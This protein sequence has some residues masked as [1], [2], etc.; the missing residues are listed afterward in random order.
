MEELTFDAVDDIAL[1]WDRYGPSNTTDLPVSIGP[2]GPLIELNSLA[3][4]HELS[5]QNISP[6]NTCKLLHRLH[7]RHNGRPTL[8]TEGDES[9]GVL[10]LGVNADEDDLEFTEFGIGMQAAARAAGIPVRAAQS[11]V[12]AI[13]EM[14]DNVLEHSGRRETALLVFRSS[15]PV[16]EFCI[17]DSGRGVLNSLR[18]NEEYS[19][20]TDSGQALQVA[21]RE[22]ESRHGR[23]S[24]HGMGFRELFR[25]LVTLRTNL[26]FRSGD[27]LLEMAEDS[28]TP[29][30]PTIAQTAYLNGFFVSVQCRAPV[31]V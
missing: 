14:R 27:H 11:L 31:S 20:L 25:G 7:E 19:Y 23:T 4:Q 6:F 18:D 30:T 22:G 8:Y 16:F 28:V 26:R 17:I 13:R 12:G 2:L 3:L 24:G 10:R 9:H 5:L 15:A 29:E 1:A 21:I